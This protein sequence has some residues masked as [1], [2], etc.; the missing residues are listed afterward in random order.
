MTPGNNRRSSS[1]IFTNGVDNKSQ[2]KIGLITVKLIKIMTNSENK[3]IEIQREPQIS[4]Y[5]KS[6]KR[7]PAP[8]C[9]KDVSI[10]RN[11]T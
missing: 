11:F 7:V 8:K 9:L 2:N 5:I 1:R 10:Q 6:I 4:A 3:T